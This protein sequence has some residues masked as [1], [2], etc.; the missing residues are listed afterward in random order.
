VPQPLQICATRSPAQRSQTHG[1]LA[2]G[3][4]VRSQREQVIFER[5]LRVRQLEHSAPAGVRALAIAS[6]PQNAHGS[7]RDGTLPA[8]ERHIGRSL[9]A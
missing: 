6:L 1:W 7:L 2:D 3:R 8:Q 5:S 4:A 9:L